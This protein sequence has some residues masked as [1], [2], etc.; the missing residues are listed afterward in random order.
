ML[1]FFLA[2]L[3]HSTN[4]ILLKIF[5][6]MLASLILSFRVLLLGK[7]EELGVLDRAVLHL[8]FLVELLVGLPGLVDLSLFLVGKVI[9]AVDLD[10]QSSLIREENLFEL[11]PNVRH[12]DLFDCLD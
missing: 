5:T 8:K 12:G 7:V 2:F 6:G 4:L 10:I 1:S 3:R 9:L 11:S